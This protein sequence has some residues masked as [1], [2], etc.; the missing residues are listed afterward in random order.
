[1]AAQLAASQEGLSSVGKC[2]PN[3]I[4][5]NK[6]ASDF[7]GTEIVYYVYVFA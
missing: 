3:Y 7:T 5:I 6:R 2:V 4:L 1:M